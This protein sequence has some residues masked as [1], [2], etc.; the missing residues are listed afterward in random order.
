MIRE[1]FPEAPLKYMPPTKHKTGDIFKANVQDAL[2]N[3]ITK[4]TGQK[5]H[6]L[7]MLTEAI[8]TPF[9]A[10]RALSIEN[11]Q[12]IFSAMESLGD[13]I[14]FKKDGIMAKR[15]D[16]VLKK[17]DELLERIEKKGL[18]ASLSEG[19]F[20]EIKRGENDGRGLDGVFE[21][22][23]DYVNPFLQSMINELEGRA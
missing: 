18:F 7:G 23:K 21:K 5:I 14:T 8:H 15:A 19:V 4:I 22:S 1:I 17:A 13:E 20:A 10:D 3:M 11:A 2:F 9:M 12:Y 6:L 16:E